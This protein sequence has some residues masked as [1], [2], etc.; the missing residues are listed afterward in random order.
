VAVNTTPLAFAADRRAA[1]DMDRKAA[2]PAADGWLKDK[3]QH[4]IPPTNLE[5]SRKRK[6]YSLQKR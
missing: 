2:A 3:R 4:I 1:V 5:D 6:Q